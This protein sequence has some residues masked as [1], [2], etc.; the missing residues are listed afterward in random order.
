MPR[1]DPPAARNMRAN[2]EHLLRGAVSVSQS[3]GR[4]PEFRC[5]PLWANFGI[6]F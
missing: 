1:F 2:T 4:R 5:L 6:S 3:Q